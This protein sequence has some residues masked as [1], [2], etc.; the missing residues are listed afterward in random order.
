V[1]RTLTLAA[2]AGVLVSSSALAQF[3]GT[4]GQPGG[5][6]MMGPMPTPPK[7]E[8]LRP[9]PV[10]VETAGGNV[11]GTIRLAAVIVAS[12][13]GQYEINPSKV[14]EIRFLARTPNTPMIRFS[15]FVAPVSGVVVT[16]GGEELKG[17]VIVQQWQVETELGSLTLN[18]ASLKLVV[19]TGHEK[20]KPEKEKAEK[21]KEKVKEKDQKRGQP[22]QPGGSNGTRGRA[23]AE[24]G[25][26]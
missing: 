3:G 13:L 2:L 8:K 21:E 14:R 25:A 4:T 15:S 18:P 1:I 20:E 22:G 19:F 16:R 24:P 26:F 23:P 17:N 9:F 7:S 5:M 10:K 6:M 11:V 12:E